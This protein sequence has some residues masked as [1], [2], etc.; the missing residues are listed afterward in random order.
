M[1]DTIPN[2]EEMIALVGKSLYD[3]WKKLC[4]FI[5]EQYDMDCLWNNGGKAWKYEYK[6]RRGGKTL[7]ALYAKENCVGFMVILGKDERLKF[8]AD[9]EN[10]AKEVQEIYDEAQTYHD[11]KWKL[12]RRIQ[13]NLT[14]PDFRVSQQFL[15]CR[16]RRDRRVFVYG[17]M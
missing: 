5:D 16:F 4:A 6:Y 12:R 15:G 7:C 11:G 13:Y 1:L 8:E 14:L 17:G 9:R 2:E 3:V 10:F